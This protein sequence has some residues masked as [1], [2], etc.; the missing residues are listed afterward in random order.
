MF[1]N[2]NTVNIVSARVSGLWSSVLAHC[3]L[4]AFHNGFEAVKFIPPFE[5]HTCL[6][7]YKSLEVQQE[8]CQW[9]AIKLAPGLYLR[10]FGGLL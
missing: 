3:K 6:R 10:S 4:A 2:R 5:A 7:N 8:F 9:L 1:I